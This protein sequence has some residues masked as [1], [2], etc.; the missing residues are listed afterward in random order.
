MLLAR[1][2]SLE[3]VDLVVP[4]PGQDIVNGI[5]DDRN[6]NQDGRRQARQRHLLLVDHLLMVRPGSCEPVG[7]AS[8]PATRGR[9]RRALAPCDLETRGETSG[10]GSRKFGFLVGGGKRLLTTVATSGLIQTR[11]L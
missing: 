11:N 1:T 7:R 2:L 10:T 8:P 9:H 3:P 5:G 6:Q 4:P